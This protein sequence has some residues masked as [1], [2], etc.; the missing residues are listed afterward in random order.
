MAQ[1][2]NN[3]DIII[4]NKVKALVRIVP[5]GV[6]LR[7]LSNQWNLGKGAGQMITISEEE[8]NKYPAKYNAYIEK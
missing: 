4:Y 6:E 5:D 3:G 1:K 2:L 7:P 8:A